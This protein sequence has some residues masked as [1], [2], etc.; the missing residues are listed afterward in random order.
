MLSARINHTVKYYV[1]YKDKN[2]FKYINNCVTIYTV[3]ARVY[4]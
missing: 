3:V 1:L 4:Y 2:N